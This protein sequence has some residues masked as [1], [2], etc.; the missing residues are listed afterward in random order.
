MAKFKAAKQ[1]KLRVSIE[2]ADE[3]A[4]LLEDLGEAAGSILEQAAEAGGKIALDDAKRRC[5]V[6]TGA[7]K[8]SLY[9]AK[10]K[11]RKPEIKRE[12]KISPGKKEYYGTFVELGTANINPQP[13][14]RPAIDENQD[15]IAK[16]IN[17][18]VLSALGRIR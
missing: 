14:M 1:R 13:F 5:P 3:V 4:K 2:G 9:L 10:S 12:V 17:Q 18:K 16:A 15:R 11:T 8:A 6:D 7:L